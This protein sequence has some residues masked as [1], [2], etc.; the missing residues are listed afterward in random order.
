MTALVLCSALAVWLVA[1]LPLAVPAA[2][3]STHRG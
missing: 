3:R 1:S 2:R